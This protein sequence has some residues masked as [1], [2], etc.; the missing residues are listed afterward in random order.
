[1]SR[2]KFQRNIRSR[3]GENVDLISF[4]IYSNDIHLGF[5]A[6]LNFLILKSVV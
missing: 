5:L 2:A 6:R 1:M 4:D 3:T